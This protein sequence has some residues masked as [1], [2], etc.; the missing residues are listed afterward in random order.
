MEVQIFLF[1]DVINANKLSQICKFVCLQELKN[2]LRIADYQ[3]KIIIVKTMGNFG[4]KTLDQ[5]L[6]DIIQDNN[7]KLELRVSAVYALRRIAPQ[8]PQKV[9]HS[10]S[11]TFFSSLHNLGKLN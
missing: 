3:E 5:P 7:N 2:R 8:I 6:L 4:H 9:G 1:I 10:L 11:K